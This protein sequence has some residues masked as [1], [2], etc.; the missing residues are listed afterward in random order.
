[1]FAQTL[2]METISLK[3]ANSHELRYAAKGV[4]Q[5]KISKLGDALVY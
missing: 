4:N 3:Q 5:I 1:M 2:V